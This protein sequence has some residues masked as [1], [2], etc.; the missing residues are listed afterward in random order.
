M[1]HLC[2]R[3]ATGGRPGELLALQWEDIDFEKCAVTFRASIGLESANS[4]KRVRKATKTRAAK[5]TVGV[6]PEAVDLLRVQWE[7]KGKP[8][9][10]LVFYA[11][12]R[13]DGSP[14]PL[15]LCNLNRDLADICADKKCEKAGLEGIICTTSGTRSR[16]T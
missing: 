1:D 13:V 4:T 9:S 3:T 2:G 16:L 15:N 5:R 12:S 10:G 6:P 14:T 7:Q 11:R 8:K